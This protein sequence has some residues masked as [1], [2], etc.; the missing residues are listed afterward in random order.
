MAIKTIEELT[1]M[2]TSELTSADTLLV[3]TPGDTSDPVKKISAEAAF[4]GGGGE[5]N[6]AIVEFDYNG[7]LVTSIDD[8]VDIKALV[9][10][11][12]A[13]IG[14]A[15]PGSGQ[16]VQLAINIIQFTANSGTLI[17]YSYDGNSGNIV[18]MFFTAA[19]LNEG[20]KFVIST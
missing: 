11:G 9:D 4:S 5:S 14:I 3:S 2:T 12:K 20:T 15:S 18:T 17:T 6:V 13:L 1:S 8:A 7:G 19:D 10:S 16:T